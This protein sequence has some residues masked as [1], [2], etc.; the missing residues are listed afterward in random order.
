MRADLYEAM[1]KT[2]D[3]NKLA[4]SVP[5]DVLSAVEAHGLRKVSAALLGLPEVT[6][7][8]AAMYIGRKL[9]ARAI[10][11]RQIRGGIEALEKLSK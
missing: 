3:F 10:E 8:T 5:E 2:V 7:S 1:M 6:E 9:A 4:E 11:S